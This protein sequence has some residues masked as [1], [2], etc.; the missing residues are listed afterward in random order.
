MTV[1]GNVW[2]QGYGKETCV[3]WTDPNDFLAAHRPLN[4]DGQV[5]CI[6]VESGRRA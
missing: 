4:P 6:G 1:L 5:L 2:D 3:F